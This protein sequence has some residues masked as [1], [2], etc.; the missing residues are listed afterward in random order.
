MD[1]FSRHFDQCVSGVAAGRVVVPNS[2]DF[3][4]LRYSALNHVDASGVPCQGSGT[5]TTRLGGYYRR[6]DA[7]WRKDRTPSS[8]RIRT[9]GFAMV[10][11][12]FWDLAA[13]PQIRLTILI[14][15]QNS[16][17]DSSSSTLSIRGIFG[18]W[19]R[20]REDSTG[21][22]HCWHDPFIYAL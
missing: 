10:A 8:H 9:A 18:Y 4:K 20:E 21:T 3:P 2:P 22:T 19:A 13:V 1:R 17:P 16:I 15:F 14:I 11:L 12:D 6:R 7:G 5:M